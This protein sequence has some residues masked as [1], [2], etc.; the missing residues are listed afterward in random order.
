MDDVVH[1]V[2]RITSKGQTTIPLEIR[3]AMGMEPGDVIRYVHRGDGSVILLP[4]S[5][6]ASALFG[7]LGRYATEPATMEAYDRSL[8]SAIGEREAER[9]AGRGKSGQ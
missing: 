2:S 8:S 5:K 7:M 1:A 4:A 3:Q 6:P 9:V